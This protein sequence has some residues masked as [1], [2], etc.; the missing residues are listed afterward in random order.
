MSTYIWSVPQIYSLEIFGMKYQQDEKR[1]VPII[2]AGRP[3]YKK[4]DE[5]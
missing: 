2:G 3:A 1:V 4:I 5:V